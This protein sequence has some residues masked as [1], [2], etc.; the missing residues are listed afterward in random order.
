VQFNEFSIANAL[1]TFDF[2]TVSNVVCV[3]NDFSDSLLQILVR[4]QYH[5]SP[6]M[7][8]GFFMYLNMR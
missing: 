2:K 1:S 7:R 6:G 5:T 4:N 3:N 8:R